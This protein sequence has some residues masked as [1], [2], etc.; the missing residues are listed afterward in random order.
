MKHKVELFHLI[1]LFLPHLGSCVVLKGI[2]PLSYIVSYTLIYHLFSREFGIE[3]FSR[4][5]NH[6]FAILTN[7][8][9]SR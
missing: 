4:D 5:L 9:F 6:D 8:R 2:L 1:C 7:H 3:I